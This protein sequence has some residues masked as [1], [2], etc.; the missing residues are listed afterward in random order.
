MPSM[1]YVSVQLPRVV[2]ILKDGGLR[3]DGLPL[4]ICGWLFQEH[5][6]RQKVFFPTAYTALFSSSPVLR[7]LPAVFSERACK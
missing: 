5:I 2:T 4:D 7:L 6:A 3:G 1:F